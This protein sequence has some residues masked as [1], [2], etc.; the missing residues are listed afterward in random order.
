[1]WLLN[2]LEGSRSPH[3]RNTGSLV[4]GH[5]L[6]VR[7]WRLVCGVVGSTFGALEQLSLQLLDS[8]REDAPSR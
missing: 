4:G 1:M 6:W 3:T 2:L 5:S 8:E 7:E